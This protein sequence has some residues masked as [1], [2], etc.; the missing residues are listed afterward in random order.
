MQKALL[1]VND[2]NLISQIIDKLFAKSTSKNP[3]ADFGSILEQLLKSNP[4]SQSKTNI[5]SK[6]LLST[7]EKIINKQK[8][9]QKNDSSKNTDPTNNDLIN[10]LSLIQNNA[11]SSFQNEKN[12]NRL[13]KKYNQTLNNIDIKELA[14]AIKTQASS[15]TRQDSS[16]PKNTKITKSNQKPNLEAIIQNSQLTITNE[17]KL[18]QITKTSNK[19][20]LDTGLQKTDS[21]NNKQ[22]NTQLIERAQDTQKLNQQENLSNKQ[23]SVIQITEKSPTNDTKASSID[24]SS[25]NTKAKV[26]EQT[27][28]QYSLDQKQQILQKT[29]ILTEKQSQQ[30]SPLQP[31]Q[32]NVTETFAQSNPQTQSSK[33]STQGNANAS[34]DLSNTKESKAVSPNA[35]NY[36]SQSKSYN[37]S[38]NTQENKSQN[39]DLQNQNTNQPQQKFAID[40]QTP[41]TLFAQ[42]TQSKPLQSEEALQNAQNLEKAQKQ[43]SQNTNNNQTQNTIAL[44][45]NAGLQKMQDTQNTNAPKQ[46]YPINHIIEKIIELQNLKPPVVKSI[47]IQINPPSLGQIDVK[48]S[49][50]SAKSL[51]ATI[52]VENQEILNLVNN[53][54]DSLKAN[55]SQQGINVSQ[56][57]V[58]SSSNLG[59]QN[60]TQNQNQQ[61]QNQ[62]LF[63]FNQ[64]FNQSN[65]GQNSFNQAFNQQKQQNYVFESTTKQIKR[66]F[67]RSSALLDISI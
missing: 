11:V 25:F 46:P 28:N 66:I 50:D 16:D 29:T 1:S 35:T 33:T 59:Q 4:Q 57:S 19:T 64:N 41:K 39:Q 18:T 62:S 38:T 60:F 51:S 13:E 49:I 5:N 10:L 27:L 44:A 20:I 26:D 14:N 21:Q 31:K 3:K 34:I 52:H 53:N 43:L 9:I 24:A 45:D 8:D 54:L 7:L 42:Q 12:T 32:S 65:N 63:Q 6:D 47:T 17:E 22:P 36:N 15:Q 58:V 37:N 56:I 55:I 48:V 30:N 40:N 23:T 61:N 67:K 2:S